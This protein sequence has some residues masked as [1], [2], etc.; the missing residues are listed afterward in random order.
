MP[1]SEAPQHPESF[2]RN[3]LLPV[4]V[5]AAIF[6]SQPERPNKTSAPRTLS[7]NSEETQKGTNLRLQGQGYMVDVVTIPDQSLSIFAEW[8]KMHV[9]WRY[10][11]EKPQPFC[12]SI[13]A[14]FSLLLA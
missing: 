5:D 6:Q 13:T 14:A 8:L 10:H 1:A 9:V 3:R 11:G 2:R 4:A 12:L 7:R